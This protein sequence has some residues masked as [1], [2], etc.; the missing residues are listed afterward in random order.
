MRVLLVEDEFELAQSV[1]DYLK[2]SE[3]INCDY[4]NTID[5]AT[6]LLELY[7]Y[8]CFLI[9]IG[10]PDGNGLDLVKIIKTK[11]NK[12]G[13][14]IISARD[15]IDD[16]IAGLNIGADDYLVKPFHLSELNARIYS[17]VRRLKFEGNSIFK[18]N[19]I[20]LDPQSREV[21][22]NG[23][24]LDLTKSEYDILYYLIT[25]KNQVISKTSIA[26]HLAGEYVDVMNSLDFVYLHIKNLRK[27]LIKA[28]CTDYIKTVYG[29]GYK[30]LME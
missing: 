5:K 13:I 8:D 19:E 22:I 11:D 23:T 1:I 27:K 9:D 25:N 29:V 3:K 12:A 16:R 6:E 7:D 20:A 10:L 2:K 17:L 21:K 30:F 14:I 15:S 18:L 26:E 24:S 4:A 28:G